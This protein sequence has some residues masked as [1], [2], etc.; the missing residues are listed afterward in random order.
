MRTWM[1]VF[2]IGV[3]LLAAM[4]LIQADERPYDVILVRNDIPIEYI[5]ALPYATMHQIPVMQVSQD[6]LTAQEEKQLSGYYQEGARRALI[7]GGVQY[8][9]SGQIEE[10]I[11]DI[12]YDVDRKWGLARESTAGIFAVELWDTSSVTVLLNGSVA[13]AYLVGAKTAMTLSCPILL[14][15][16][17]GINA[18]TLQA[19]DDLSCEEAYIVGP[20]IGESV[21]A[22]LDERG[23][24]Y[25]L[26]GTD[27]NPHDVEPRDTGGITLSPA[28]LLAGIGIGLAAM[29]A[30]LWPRRGAPQEKREVSVPLFVLTDDERK[31][32]MTIEESGGALRQDALPDLTT[33]SRPKV[34]RI[35]NDLEGKKIIT[36]EKKGKTYKVILAKKFIIEDESAPSS[37]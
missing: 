27:I 28:S 15:D 35:I 30:I 32:V 19:L 26:I 24:S 5:I 2:V 18:D 25:T 1:Y 10:T 8:A 36:R 13:E 3:V 12:G 9:I 31:V 16:E 33:Y 22:T 6:V 20:S 14:I 34:S 17:N 23:I 11:R 21:L 29:F 4:P 37:P 7:L